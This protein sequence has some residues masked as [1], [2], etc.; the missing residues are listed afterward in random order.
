MGAV[1]SATDVRAAVREQVQS[2]GA[3]FVETPVA[4][5]QAEGTGGYAKALDEES[6]Q[7]QREA[8]SKVVAES[9][10][11][12][13]TAAI[14]GKKAPILLTAEMVKLM[15]PRSVVVDLAAERGGNCEL[16]KPGQT[17]EAHGVTIIGND[18]LPSDV[19]YHASQMFGKNVVTFLQHLVGEGLP[20]K[21]NMEDE[22]TRD[23]L[24]CRDGELVN[25]RVRELLAK[26]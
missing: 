13:T 17:I 7:R 1:V 12:I 4:A 10:V 26:G 18:N 6:Y 16:T 24:I 2:L 9:D 3:R 11:V 21:V 25:A 14:P 23:T 5:A 15:Q 8:M 19:P 22:I 20:G